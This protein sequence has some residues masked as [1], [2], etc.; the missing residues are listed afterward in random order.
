MM[1]HAFTPVDYESEI[2]RLLLL[3]P[4]RATQ[5]FEDESLRDWFVGQLM[6]ETGGKANPKIAREV[7]DQALTKRPQEL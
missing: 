2:E 1:D 3:Y 5:A 6:K 4:S 7:L